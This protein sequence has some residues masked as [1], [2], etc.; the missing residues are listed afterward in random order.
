MASYLLR[1]KLDSM[2]ISTIV[3]DANM[4]NILASN[5]WNYAYSYQAS[6]SLITD[7]KN[8]YPTLKYFIDIHRDSIPKSAS[9]ASLN[10]KNYA[11]ILFVVGK[12]Y[13]TWQDN[14]NFSN[15]LNDLLNTYYSGIS[16]GIIT[17]SGTGVNG[18]YNQ[19][20]SP[21]C[22]LIE[23]GGNENTIEEV[24]NTIEVLADILNKYISGAAK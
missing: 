10:N 2:G 8:K 3:E 19:N 6:A 15:K 4:S 13:N 14:Y 7:K 5:N 18:I 12:D 21:N 23:V 24:Y 1:E 16:R 22:I 11:K 17:K 20:L 9:T